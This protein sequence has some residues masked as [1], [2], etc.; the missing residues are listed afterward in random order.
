MLWLQS[1]LQE[2][3]K[4]KRDEVLG[5]LHTAQGMAGQGHINKKQ[6]VSGESSSTIL[7]AATIQIT[8]H[9]KDFRYTD[10]MMSSLKKS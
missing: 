9:E 6:G 10:V 2:T 4:L 3:G 5:S 8:K 7:N 1:V